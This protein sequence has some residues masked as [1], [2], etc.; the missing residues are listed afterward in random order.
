MTPSAH[1]VARRPGSA[2]P[3]Q[4]HE[5]GHGEQQQRE[6]EEGVLLGRVGRQRV[7]S[8]AAPASDRLRPRPVRGDVLGVHQG[9]KPVPWKRCGPAKCSHSGY[10]SS[11]PATSAVTPSPRRKPGSAARASARRAGCTAQTA[12]KTPSARAV[13]KSPWRRS[14]RRPRPA[15]R[16]SPRPQPVPGRRSRNAPDQQWHQPA[17]GPVQVGV[18][19]RDHAGGVADEEPPTAGGQPAADQVPGDSQYQ[20]SAVAARLRVRITR[21]VAGGPQVVSGAKTP[22]TR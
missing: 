7:P 9:S 22:R 10:A 11:T 6:A 8:P 3:P 12:R 4:Q 18:G 19:V 2:P 15:R 21:N 16:G 17:G 5:A 14:R 1:S 13:K 20:A